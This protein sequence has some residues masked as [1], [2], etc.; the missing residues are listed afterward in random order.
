METVFPTVEPAAGDVMDTLGAT[1]SA[2]VLDTVTLT[3]V[4]ETLP[5]VSVARAATVWLPLERLD[6]FQDQDHALVPL[7][8]CQ[9]PPST[10]TSTKAMETLSAAEPVTDTVLPTVDPD[11]GLAMLS[12]GAVV[13][14]EEDGQLL[15]RQLLPPPPVLPSASGA[16]PTKVTAAS[17]PS[18]KRAG[19]GN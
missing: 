8:R 2:A 19:V 6:V 13:S 1:L 17:A 3:L 11:A 12:V 16:P 14:S 7:A 5:L 15:C 10:A 18:A 9:V 4:E